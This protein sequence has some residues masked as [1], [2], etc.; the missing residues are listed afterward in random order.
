M[1]S[2]ATAILEVYE[3]DLD[4]HSK[5]RPFG[6]L[7]VQLTFEVPLVARPSDCQLAVRVSAPAGGKRCIS[8]VDRI[9]LT[10]QT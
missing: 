9:R 5:D 10:G 3:S 8:A 6:V 7:D 2:I 1:T 4:Q